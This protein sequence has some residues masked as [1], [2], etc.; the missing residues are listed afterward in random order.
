[1]DEFFQELIKNSFLIGLQI[2]NGQDDLKSHA[3]GFKREILEKENHTYFFPDYDVKD[4]KKLSEFIKKLYQVR[5]FDS[6][7]IANVGKELYCTI[8]DMSNK[9]YNWFIRHNSHEI[10][11]EEEIG[12][13]EYFTPF[14]KSEKIKVYYKIPKELVLGSIKHNDKS[15]EMF[16][17]PNPNYYMNLDEESRNTFIESYKKIISNEI[18]NEDYNQEYP[19]SDIMTLSKRMQ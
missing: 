15:G 10:C 11:A 3:M 2:E 18:V 16:F 7:S 6:L 12:W 8:F 4:G 1:M 13:F 14:Y 5:Q 19:C 17:I 9:D